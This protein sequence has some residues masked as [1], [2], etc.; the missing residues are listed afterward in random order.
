MTGDNDPQYI[1]SV[2]AFIAEILTLEKK[3]GRHYPFKCSG[4]GRKFYDWYKC[5]YSRKMKYARLHGWTI[6][7][8]D[9]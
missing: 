5:H 6:E 1:P 2:P 4:D 7:K 3:Y 9:A 8:E